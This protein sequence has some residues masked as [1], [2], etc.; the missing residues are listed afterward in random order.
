MENADIYVNSVSK[1]DHTGGT[2]SPGSLSH[3][4]IGR[5][6]SHLHF[7]GNIDDVRIYNRALSE[8]EVERLY[9]EGDRWTVMD[10]VWN[11]GD[12]ITDERDN[13]VYSTVQIGE[14]C[15]L[16]EDLRYDDGCSGNTWND[17]APFNAC[18]LQGGGYDGMVYQWAAAMDGS[19]QE[20]AQGL[21]PNGWHI[22]TD[23]E[24]KI[25]EGYVDSTYG[26]PD[27]EWDKINDSRG[28]DAGDQLKDPEEGWC[29]STPC[30]EFGWNALPGGRYDTSGTVDSFD[31]YGFWW[32]SNADGNEALRRRLRYDA[33]GIHRRNLSQA[34][35]FSIRCLRD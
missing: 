22:P 3:V 15:W 10:H 31:S 9:R 27:S 26:Y 21:C 29:Y 20:G 2:W 12:Y 18:G 30:G 6:A 8:E 33:S 28:D 23:E 32:S 19:T 13:E 5:F 11:C 34:F 16:A 17:T 4:R 14:Q 7:E 25:L 35:G 1:G 24:F